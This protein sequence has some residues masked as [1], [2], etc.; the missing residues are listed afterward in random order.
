MGLFETFAHAKPC[1]IMK[2]LREPESVW[3]ISKLAK[4]SGATFVY[5]SH[6][7]ARLLENNY[8]TVESKGK[9]K[10]VK[11]TEKGMKAANSIE[12]LMKSTEV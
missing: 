4:G 10:F 1:I 11:L 9:K 3:H 2:L 5:T 7:V 8:V 12:E 6:I